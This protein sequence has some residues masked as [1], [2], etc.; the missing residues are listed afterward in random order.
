MFRIYYN[1]SVRVGQKLQNTI[2]GF[3]TIMEKV[4]KDYDNR[5]ARRMKRREE[6]IRE[7]D[8]NHIAGRT[9]E[10]DEEEEDDDDD[11]SDSK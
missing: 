7:Q 4:Q 6:E 11:G 1:L 10:D 5:I 2:P 9:E 8:L 3:D